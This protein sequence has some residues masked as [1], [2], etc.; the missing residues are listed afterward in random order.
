MRMIDKV[1]RGRFLVLGFASRDRA[2]FDFMTQDLPEHMLERFK[3]HQEEI[4]LGALAT[5]KIEHPNAY[6]GFILGFAS[7]YERDMFLS[8]LSRQLDSIEF[9][10]PRSNLN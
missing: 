5:I 10:I 6:A 1:I 2:W 9:L 7:A 8:K 4:L 3:A